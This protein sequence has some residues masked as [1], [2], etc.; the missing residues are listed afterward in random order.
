MHAI[1]ATWKN[2]QIV[3]DESA[4]WPEGCRLRVEPVCDGETLGIREEDWPDTATGIARLLALMDRIEPLTM[5][6]E[7]EAAW[8]AAL[9]DQ[10]EFE[11]ARFLEY[12]DKVGR[13]WE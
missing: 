6:P 9:K 1:K 2:G 7:E 5:T 11:K 12:G 13:V 3:P 4:D 10:K 8:R